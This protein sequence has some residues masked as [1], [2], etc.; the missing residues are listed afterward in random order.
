MRDVER[1]DQREQVHP[2]IDGDANHPAWFVAL[3]EQFED[4]IVEEVGDEWVSCENEEED[5]ESEHEGGWL[6]VVVHVEAVLIN[7]T[8]F[9][10]LVSHFLIVR[11]EVDAHVADIA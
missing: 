8:R 3:K 5:A 2:D 9:F 6:L 10:R 11:G 7:D 4:E 1:T